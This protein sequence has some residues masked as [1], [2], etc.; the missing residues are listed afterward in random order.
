VQGEPNEKFLREQADKESGLSR[1][2]RCSINPSRE[3]S[4][5]KRGEEGSRQKRRK[6]VVSKRK[7]TTEENKGSG[8]FDHKRLE[9]IGKSTLGRKGG[10]SKR[11]EVFWKGAGRYRAQA[12]G[13]VKQGLS[14]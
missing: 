11:D 12:Y 6:V 14:G 5:R 7:I 10:S 4:V 1:I 9:P 8:D 3:P 2:N 13:L